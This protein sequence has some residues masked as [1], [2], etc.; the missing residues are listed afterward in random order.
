MW[1]PLLR[2]LV[3]MSSGFYR[4]FISH[5]VMFKNVNSLWRQLTFEGRDIFYG[6][7]S[8]R[9]ILT[10][11]SM[12]FPFH[13][14]NVW[15]LAHQKI[16]NSYSLDPHVVDWFKYACLFSPCWHIWTKLLHFSKRNWFLKLFL[17]ADLKYKVILLLYKYLVFL[18]HKKH[19]KIKKMHMP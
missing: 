1:G 5:S 10:Q 19:W 2:T 3:I 16:F 14:V 8:S 7:L 11:S 13:L 15:S 17:K 6:D 12:P 4:A 18:R 9:L